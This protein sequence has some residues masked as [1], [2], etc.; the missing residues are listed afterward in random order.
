MDSLRI[1]GGGGGGGGTRPLQPSPPESNDPGTS[2]TAVAISGR[3][4]GNSV[5]T[6]LSLIYIV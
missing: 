4:S 5:I 1:G 6:L 3:I 2:G